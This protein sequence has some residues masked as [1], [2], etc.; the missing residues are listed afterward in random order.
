MLKVNETNI[1]G[2]IVS[3][4]EDCR[5]NHDVMKATLACIIRMNIVVNYKPNSNSIFFILWVLGDKVIIRIHTH[6][7]VN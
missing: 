6:I 5:S 1:A 7:H 4:E 3:T 2:L